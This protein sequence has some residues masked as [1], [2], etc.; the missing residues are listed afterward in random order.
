MTDSL[1]NEYSPSGI[2]S[3]VLAALAEPPQTSVRLLLASAA[4][5]RY[6]ATEAP[7]LNLSDGA[8]AEAQAA[9]LAQ[10]LNYEHSA[11]VLAGVADPS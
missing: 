3:A 4:N 9:A 11:R 1:L 5:Q 10:A 7:M 2:S 6:L 8:K